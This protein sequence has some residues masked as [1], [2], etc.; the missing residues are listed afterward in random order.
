[1][2]VLIK[3]AVFFFK[4][5]FW[6]IHFFGPYLILLLATPSDAEFTKTTKTGRF[7]ESSNGNNKVNLLNGQHLTIVS[8]DVR[9]LELKFGALVCNSLLLLS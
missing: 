5:L 1:M 6:N 7:S 2:V 9:F 3:N 4:I 8:L